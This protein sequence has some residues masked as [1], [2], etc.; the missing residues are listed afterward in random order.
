MSLI[1]TYNTIQSVVIFVS[2][3]F[4]SVACFSKSKV[5]SHTLKNNGSVDGDGGLY[6]GLSVGQS[7]G[8]VQTVKYGSPWNFIQAF[9]VCRGYILLIGIIP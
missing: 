8:L 4:V 7:T 1:D 9:M 3:L 5:F 2:S 6:V